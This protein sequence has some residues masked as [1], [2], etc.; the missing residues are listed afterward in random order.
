M[1]RRLV[2]SF[3]LRAPLSP[4]ALAALA[5]SFSACQLLL[6]LPDPSA[7][8]DGVADADRSDAQ[9]DGQSI[10]TDASAADAVADGGTFAAPV[11][12]VSDAPGEAVTTDNA[13]VYWVRPGAGGGVFYA[14]K[15]DNAKATAWR[16]DD[17]IA[18]WSRLV[19]TG[20]G[21]YFVSNESNCSQLR[22]ATDSF[23]LGFSSFG[24]NCTRVTSFRA[25]SCCRLIAKYPRWS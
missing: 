22:R 3:R 24:G 16:P 23:V 15:V 17:A 11:T 20:N 5:V 4:F 6:D 8:S 25:S 21:V 10:A 14:P 2:R 18:A 7:P 1:T 12:I 19:A 13:Y 9:R